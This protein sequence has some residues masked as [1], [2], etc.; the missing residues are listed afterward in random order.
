MV[1]ERRFSGNGADRR[2]SSFRKNGPNSRGRGGSRG[3][4]G[5]SRGFIEKRD[6]PRI[7]GVCFRC[8]KSGHTMQQ[9]REEVTDD[10]NSK[11]TE[12][13]RIICFRCGSTA[14]SLSMCPIPAKYE[15]LKAVVN[16]EQSPDDNSASRT[17]EILPF[18]TCFICKSEGHLSRHCPQNTNG[19]YPKG[20][21]CRFCG[22]KWHFLKDCPEKR[23]ENSSHTTLTKEEKEAAQLEA[24]LEPVSLQVPATQK[25]SKKVKKDIVF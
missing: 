1:P 20:G 24:W 9:C 11:N 2:P 21:G 23:H 14:H 13:G 25:A 5:P 8:R 15:S 19:V 6:Q 22:S 17:V 16:S 4:A 10:K 18:A 3:A 7:Q 12:R